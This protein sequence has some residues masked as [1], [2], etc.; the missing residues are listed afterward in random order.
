V[1]C[2]GPPGKEVVLV[3]FYTAGS[4]RGVR[5]PGSDAGYASPRLLVVASGGGSAVAR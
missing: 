1:A 4:A 3:V 2:S 5:E